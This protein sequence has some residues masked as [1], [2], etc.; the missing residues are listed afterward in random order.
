MRITIDTKA[1]EIEIH[2]SFTYSEFDALMNSLPAAYRHFTFKTT[3][4]VYPP[5]QYYIP[6]S[7]D[8]S[9]ITITTSST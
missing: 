2:G 6:F 9:G 7:D 3:P 5:W 8:G 4:V 1:R